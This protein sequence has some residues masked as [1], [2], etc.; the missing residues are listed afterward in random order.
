M[1]KGS[2]I[3]WLGIIATVGGIG[4]TL[5]NSFVSEK[6]TDAIIEDK[7]QKAVAKLTEKGE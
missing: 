6:K 1:T 5:L 2:G 7:V 3:K 4:I